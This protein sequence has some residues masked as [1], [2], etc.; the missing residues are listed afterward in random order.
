MQGHGIEWKHIYL[1]T[2][3]RS[4]AKEMSSMRRKS[5]FSGRDWFTIEGYD[6]Q[7]FP[8]LRRMAH[9]PDSL[10]TYHLSR[11]FYSASSQ[12]NQNN[13]L[14]Y[15]PGVAWRTTLPSHQLS[16]LTNSGGKNNKSKRRATTMM[17]VN[18]NATF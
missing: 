6:P 1:G 17:G 8:R 16:N 10:V 2:L 12:S 14:A 3:M 18:S 7:N 4:L 13:F 9:R 11:R 5:A 15:F